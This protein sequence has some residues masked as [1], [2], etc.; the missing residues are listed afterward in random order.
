MSGTLDLIVVVVK[1][2]DVSTSEL[3]NLA[4][5]AA[6]TATDIENLHALLNADA[7]GEVVLMSGNSLVERL[8][9]R[10][11]AEVERLAPSVFVQIG[12]KVVVAI[13]EVRTVMLPTNQQAVKV[14]MRKT[15][16][17]V[18]VAYSAVRACNSAISLHL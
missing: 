10:E 2:G 11:T 9:E 15:Y 16:C 18:K 14:A 4:G 6:N 17:R 7:V 12:R 3:G 5:R 13:V 1:T 8:S